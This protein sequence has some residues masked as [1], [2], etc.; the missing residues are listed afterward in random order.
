MGDNNNTPQKS[1]EEVDIIQLFD[2]FERKIKGGFKRIFLIFNW[3]FSV[4]IFSL[5]ELQ[6]NIKILGP[7]LI[8]AIAIGVFLDKKNDPEYSSEMLVQPYFEAK[9]QLYAN[10]EYYNSLLAEKDYNTLREIFGID[11]SQAE[12]IKG[13]EMYPGPETE[14]QLRKEYYGFVEDITLGQVKS[15]KSNDEEEPNTT[16]LDVSFEQFVEGRSIYSS[17][18]YMIK[19][20]S[21][22]KDIFK[23]LEKGLNNSFDNQYSTKNMK[24]R[25]SV[26]LLRKKTIE[27]SIKEIEKLQDIYVE[28]FKENVKATSSQIK[29]GSEGFALADSKVETKEYELLEKKTK[30]YEEL[31]VLQESKVVE[32]TFFDVISSFPEIGRLEGVPFYKKKT[33][34]FP[35]IAFVLFVLCLLSIKSYKFVEKYE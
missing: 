17:D 12:M 25:D 2:F 35:V 30:L 14:N 1:S 31:R 16:V 10:I 28:A 3:L 32:D 22:K 20:V 7:V 5:Q 27:E 21:S 34:L 26:I 33:I 15:N 24:K 23:H 13:F 29:V 9:Y 6:K 8:I 11:L 18:K 19:A 4:F